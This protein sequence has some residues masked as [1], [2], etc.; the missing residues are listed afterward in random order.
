MTKIILVRH[1][2]T[3]WNV[4]AGNGEHFRGHIDLPLNDVGLAQAQSLAERLAHEP[5]AAIYS[6]PLQRALHGR[7]G[8][9]RTK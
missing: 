7:K 2:Q 5:I 6:S 3:A 4:G 9:S 8:V 1:G